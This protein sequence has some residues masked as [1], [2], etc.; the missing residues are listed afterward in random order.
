MDMA[1]NQPQARKVSKWHRAD[2]SRIS[3]MGLRG[4]LHVTSLED[5]D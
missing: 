2:L 3:A 4:A 1:R 5:S